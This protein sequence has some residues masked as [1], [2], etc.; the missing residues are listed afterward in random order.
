M[1]SS[2]STDMKR[3]CFLANIRE[4]PPVLNGRINIVTFLEAS[5]DLVKIVGT[6]ILFTL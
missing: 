3:K 1:A 2:S 4:F 5:S 6:Y